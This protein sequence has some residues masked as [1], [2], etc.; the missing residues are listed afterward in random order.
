M[1]RAEEA[2]W[3]GLTI[4]RWYGERDRP[5]EVLSQTAVWY[6]TGFPPVPIRWVLI[7]DPQ[8][9]FATHTQALLCTDRDV[10][11]VQSITGFIL[12]WQLEVTFHEVRAH[13]GVE[14]QRQ[15]SDRAILR[16]TPALLGRFSVVTLL[17]PE[18]LVSTPPAAILHQAAWYA[19]TTPTFSDAVAFVR[20]RLWTSTIFPTSP[21]AQDLVKV[22]RALLDH[23]TELLCYAA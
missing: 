3:I 22:P 19:K 9:H 20:R 8:G 4:P 18:H 1:D 12:R 2:A 17:A 7:R 5:I 14:T 21:Y 16:T 11:P 6:S 10:E 13:L 15:W 23:L